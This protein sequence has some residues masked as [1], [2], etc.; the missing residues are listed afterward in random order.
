MRHSLPMWFPDPLRSCMRT[1]S[2][3][4][5]LL[6]YSLVMLTILGLR[7]VKEAS[8]FVILSIILKHMKVGNRSWKN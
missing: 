7:H 3:L 4:F 5:I 1:M 2:M 8:K 6:R